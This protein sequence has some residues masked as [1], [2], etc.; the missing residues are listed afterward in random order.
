[1]TLEEKFKAV[2]DLSMKYYCEDTPEAKELSLSY[3]AGVSEEARVIHRNSIV[4]DTCSFS[5]EGYDWHLE[6][7]GLTGLNCTVIGTKDGPGESIRNIID[8]ES[9]ILNTPKL[10][11]IQKADDLL[12]A[13]RSGRTGIIIGSQSAQFLHHNDLEA[14]VMLFSRLGLRITTLAYNWRTFAADGCYAQAN[15][16]LARDGVELVRLLEKYGVTVDLSHVGERSTLDALEMATKPMIFSHSNPLKLFKHP[17]NITDEQ[18]KK[19]AATGGVV[20][21]TSFPVTL[22]EKGKS[23][24][25]ID[26]FVDCIAYYADTIGV[27][28]VGLGID[29]NANAG[30]YERRKVVMLSNT[31]NSMQ[32][33]ESLGFI[34]YEA[35]RGLLGSFPEGLES[36]ANIVN[37]IDHMLKRGFSK[38]DIQKIIGG[39]WY[40]VFKETWK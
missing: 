37:I 28:H 33:Q 18:A 10:M 27:D 34:S 9:A 11:L 17:R 39:N 36:L 3:N 7:A 38:N 21:V 4:I 16:G 35:G 40:R 8:Y 23:F 12:E 22:W 26:T 32:G 5:L 25:T 19:C 14:A 20:G 29:S 1:M 15:G 30:A 2:H 31:T 6:Q 24:P 13:K